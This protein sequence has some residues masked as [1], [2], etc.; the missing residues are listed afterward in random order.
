MDNIYFEDQQKYRNGDIIDQPNVLKEKAGDGG[1]PPELLQQAE[2]YI[3]NNDV[4][5]T[6]TAETY[7]ELLERAL[8][9]SEQ[10]GV[11]E[12]QAFEAILFPLSQ[13][14]A[15]GAMFKYSI[16]SEITAMLINFLEVIEKLDQEAI[17]ITRAYKMTLKALLLRN[18]HGVEATEKDAV[19]KEALKDACLRYFNKHKKQ[20][21]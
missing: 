21:L 16:I 19:L 3:E 7:F 1:I 5:F 15:Q 9:M 11:D 20:P 4:D 18:R 10:D 8:T 13:L 14:K 17:N 6:E 12:E 2:A